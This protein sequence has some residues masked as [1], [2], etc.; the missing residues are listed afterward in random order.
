MY[1]YIETIFA[2]HSTVY[3]LYTALIVCRMLCW[4]VYPGAKVCV[5][6]SEARYYAKTRAFASCYALFR[7]LTRCA[8]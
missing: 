1:I 8:Q 6:M 7:K 2:Y 3:I 4:Y 5:I